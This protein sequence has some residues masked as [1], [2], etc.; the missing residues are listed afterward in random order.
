MR[1]NLLV[2]FDTKIEFDFRFKFRGTYSGK[3]KY[4][5][6]IIAKSTVTAKKK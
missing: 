1:I 3:T 5:T 6:N 4:L 2:M